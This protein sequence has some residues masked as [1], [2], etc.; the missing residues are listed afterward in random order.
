MQKAEAPEELLEECCLEE[1]QKW[2]PLKM[3]RAYPK[4]PEG[5]KGRGAGGMPGC[6]RAGPSA[7]GSP[8][9]E[10][11][12]TARAAVERGREGEAVQTWGHISR[13]VVAPHSAASSIH[14]QC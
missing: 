3:P 8:S 2:Q 7:P 6:A 1:Y 12:V 10:T 9:R 14:L 13:I 11:R 5:R 4:E